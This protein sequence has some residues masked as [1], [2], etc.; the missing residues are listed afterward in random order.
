MR[1]ERYFVERNND[2]VIRVLDR[3]VT[4]DTELWG[5]YLRDGVWVK[6]RSVTD[7]VVGADFA[8]EITVAEAREIA[9]HMGGHLENDVASTSISSAEHVAKL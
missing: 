2:G 5:E 7:L 6:D 8:D 3:V 1:T 9:E 4:T